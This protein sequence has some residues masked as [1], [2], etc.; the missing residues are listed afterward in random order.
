MTKPGVDADG[1]AETDAGLLCPLSRRR[2]RT[3]ADLD[4]RV[5]DMRQ[6]LPEVSHVEIGPADGTIPEMIADGSELY[7]G[8]NRFPIRLRS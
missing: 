7:S 8:G 2:L 3:F 1:V 6:H 5:M 4:I